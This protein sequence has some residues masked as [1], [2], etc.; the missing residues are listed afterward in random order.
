MDGQVTNVINFRAMRDAQSTATV[1]MVH[2]CVLE[3]GMANI[4]LFVSYYNNVT[5]SYI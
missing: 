1:E 5:Y 2:A 3:D 4:V